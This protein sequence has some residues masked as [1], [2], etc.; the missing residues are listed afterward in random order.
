MNV[1]PSSFF[2]T[3]FK[4]NTLPTVNPVIPD[5][6]DA[7]SDAENGTY[8]EPIAS[9]GHRPHM[10]GQSH[11]QFNRMTSQKPDIPDGHGM[12]FDANTYNE[13]FLQEIKCK[14]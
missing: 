4:S 5:N 8:W 3:Y 10:P 6:M 14:G 9:A 7:R 2:L 11:E 1:F 12:V 13:D